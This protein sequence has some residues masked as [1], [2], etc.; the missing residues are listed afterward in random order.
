M[1]EEMRI[2]SVCPCGTSRVLLHAIKSYDMGPSHFRSERKVC[3]GFLSS[4]KNP[5]LWPGSNPQSLGPVASTL[6]ST[7]PR[8]LRFGGAFSVTVH[9][10]PPW[11]V[12]CCRTCR[13]FYIKQHSYIKPCMNQDSCCQLLCLCSCTYTIDLEVKLKISL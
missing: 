8:R 6:T 5:S 12:Y 3:C 10:L 1:G 13:Y 2:L 11:H 9:N 7:P 4:L